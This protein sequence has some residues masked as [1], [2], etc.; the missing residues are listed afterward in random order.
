M[1]FKE[2]E[3]FSSRDG[4]KFRI[5]K[6]GSSGGQG[7]TWFVEKADTKERLYFKI[8][9]EQD[10][11]V[12]CRKK[13]NIQHLYS[14]RDVYLPTL[15]DRRFK[16]TLPHYIYDKSGEFGYIMPMG[17]GKEI[18]EYMLN[19]AFVN[20]PINER[21]KIILDIADSIKWLQQN[22]LCYQDI[23]H[24]NFMYDPNSKYPIT[25]IDCDNIASN[26][27]VH[28]GDRS[29]V[30]GTSFYMA[31]EVVFHKDKMSQNADNY[32][33]AVLFYKILTGSTDSPYH[34]QIL[35]SKRPR[36]FDM[37]GAA[38][39]YEEDPDYGTDWLTFV[40]DDQN[41]SNAIN[42][43][44]FKDPE[45]KKEMRQIIDNWKCVPDSIKELLIQ[46]FRNPLDETFYKKR[47]TA[48]KWYNTVNTILYQGNSP[49]TATAA[50]ANSVKVKV[51]NIKKA[52]EL[53]IA[54]PDECKEV[55]KDSFKLDG[56]HIGL[57]KTI[58]GRIEKENGKYV[59]I[60][61][62]PYAITCNH[63]NK[64]M[65]RYDKIEIADKMEISIAI[66]PTKK[67]IFNL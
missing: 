19:K 48:S 7:S 23:S 65:N 58:L 12:K 32:A 38:E 42:L 62:C 52:S 28:N 43:D 8:I 30:K 46:A 41:K 9:N 4:T 6:T 60:S 22:G 33:L 49:S 67:I 24:K 63:I 15:K 56:Y 14:K 21:L 55:V 29:F 3:L 31:P 64:L 45:R 59:F 20:M 25:L 26:S 57:S 39:L 50:N 44:Q 53:I 13:E 35:Y 11:S 40:F 5:V 16:I 66:K 27:D 54:F 18:N 51:S 10:P 61:E 36:P 2:N 34:G 37:A 17:S 47:P 1:T